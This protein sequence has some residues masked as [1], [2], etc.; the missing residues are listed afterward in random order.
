MNI[1]FNHKNDIYFYKGAT[2]N[3]FD[4][5]KFFFLFCSVL[6]FFILLVFFFIIFILF[7]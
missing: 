6:F 2:R 3:T 7:P 4:K 1:N 5:I